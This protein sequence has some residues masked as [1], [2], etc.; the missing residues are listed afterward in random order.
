MTVYARIR[1]IR[2]FPRTVSQVHTYM[3]MMVMTAPQSLHIAYAPRIE[4][5]TT[6][7]NH[8]RV[9]WGAM[10]TVETIRKHIR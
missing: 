9:T 2:T 1:R 8:I 10:T 5:H 4:A 6:Q 7:W 3:Y